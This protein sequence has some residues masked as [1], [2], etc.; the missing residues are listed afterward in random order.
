[1]TNE[2]FAAHLGVAVRTVAYWRERP[3]VV[4]RPAM[5]EILDTA[6]AQSPASAQAQFSLILSPGSAWHRTA[7]AG[8]GD[9]LASLTEWITSSN[10]SDRLIEDIGAAVDDLAARHAQASARP[11]LADVQAVHRQIQALLRGG[12]QRLRQTRELIRADGTALAHASVL[13]GDLG[14]DLAA[15][16]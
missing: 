14:M 5:Q 11:L 8:R 6:L 4:P 2:S 10:A 9:D 7:K 1:M 12:R 15:E 16:T 3:D 13:L